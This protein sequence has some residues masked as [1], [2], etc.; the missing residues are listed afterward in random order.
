MS[1]RQNTMLGSGIFKGSE[2]G[3][4][5]TEVLVALA[6]LAAVGVAFLAGMQTSSKSVIISQQSVTA[7]NL[8]KSQ[9]EDTKLQTYVVAATSYP[10]ITIPPDLAAQG[11]SITVVAVP[12]Q[13]PDKGEQRITVTVS[14]NGQTLFT[15]AGYKVQR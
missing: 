12:K 5:L 10:T 6:I 3:Q 4:T 1:R 15:L 11:Y 9:I 2:L 13:S 14:Q 7:E 8:A